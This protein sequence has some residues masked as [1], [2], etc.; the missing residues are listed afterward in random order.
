MTPPQPD[1]A[2]TLAQWCAERARGSLHLRDG[3]LVQVEDG[4]IVHAVTG[5]RCFE[6]TRALRHLLD[7]NV[8]V[9]RVSQTRPGGRTL[10]DASGEFTLLDALRQNDERRHC[11]MDPERWLAHLGGFPGV[12]LVGLLDARGAATCSV[13]ALPGW[14]R[15]F[16]ALL[17]PATRIAGSSGAAHPRR[18]EA[19]T[20]SRRLLVVPTAPGFLCA[21]L[22]GHEA[23]ECLLD[24]LGS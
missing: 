10:P 11:R 21:R 2:A 19:V 18:I 20:G 13:P 7:R 6:G 12:D 9:V 3:G 5:D 16:L 17:Q 14:E 8:P 23:R 22:H 1:L 15:P 24:E 4:R